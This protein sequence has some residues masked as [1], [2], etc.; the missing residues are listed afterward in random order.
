MDKSWSENNKE[1]Q[2][3]LTKEATFK[4]AIQKFWDRII[5]KD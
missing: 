2:K 3:L 1:I 4:D 5:R